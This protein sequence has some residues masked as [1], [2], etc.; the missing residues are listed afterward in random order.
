MKINV[1]FNQIKNKIVWLYH[2]KLKI[3]QWRKG[4]LNILQFRWILHLGSQLMDVNQKPTLIISP[5]Q[6][7]E[8]LGCGGLIAL[9]QE[10]G[11]PLKVVFITDG[12]ASHSWH[13]NFQSG[14]IVPIRKQEA[15]TALGILGVDPSQIQFLDKPDSKLRYLKEDQ[16][17][18]IIQELVDILQSFQP[19]EVYVTHRQD[20]TNEHEATYQLVNAAII[21]SGIKVDLLEYPIWMLWNAV[22]FRDLKLDELAGAYRLPIH[23]IIDK[24]K[25]AI[26]AYHSQYTPID[27]HSS[28]VLKP[29]FLKR[30]NIPYEVF[31]KTN[32]L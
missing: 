27:I 18:E 23:S 3:P 7:D 32:S 25:Q 6:D 21:H 29:A 1:F 13:A 17:Q 12:S 4:L 16:R 9:K 22:L 24:K 10:K 26:A 31:F 8:V 5:H 28:P 2:Y 11:V 19:Q 14:E 30:F 15:I 20:R